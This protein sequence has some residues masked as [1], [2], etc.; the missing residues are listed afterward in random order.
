[1]AV[2]VDPLVELLRADRDGYVAAARR[3]YEQATTAAANP[4]V[5]AHH[6]DVARGALLAAGALHRDLKLLHEITDED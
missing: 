5:A 1:M 4:S 2:K 3:A 6:L